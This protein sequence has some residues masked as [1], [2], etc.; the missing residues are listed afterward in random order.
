MKKKSPNM[1][2][3]KFEI[4]I[5]NNPHHVYKLDKVNNDKGRGNYMNSEVNSINKYQ[6][7]I[8][9][10]ENEQLPKRYQKIP[11]HY[12]FNV[13]F[14]GRKKGILVS[15]GYKAPDVVKNNVYSS[16]VSIETIRMAFLLAVM[17][18]LEVCADD[19]S[20]VFLYGIIIEKIC[21]CKK[22]IW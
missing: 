3:F 19:V 22:G 21:Y 2:K 10:E 17:N 6:T 15:R 8:M 14:D 16:V 7:F 11:Y 18:K 9:L 12:V 13:K 4:Q 20:T 1:P 5:L